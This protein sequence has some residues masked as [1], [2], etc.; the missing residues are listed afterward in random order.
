MVNGSPINY[1]EASRVERYAENG[2]EDV[3]GAE[4][5]IAASAVLSASHLRVS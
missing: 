5:S 1:Y 4:T 2:E 3:G